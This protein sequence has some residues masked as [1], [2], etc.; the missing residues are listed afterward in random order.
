[1]YISHDFNIEKWKKEVKNIDRVNS[2]M[3]ES[4][5]KV[6]AFIDKA[7]EAVPKN[8]INESI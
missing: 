8:F 1:I 4:S 7:T 5:S 6:A 2:G 3:K